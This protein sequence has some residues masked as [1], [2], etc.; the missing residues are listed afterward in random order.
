MSG[1]LIDGKPI[2]MKVRAEAAERAAAFAQAYGR[3]PGLHVVLVGED[4]ASQVYVRN[5][6]RAC[7]KAGLAGQ[8]HRVS[9]DLGQGRLLALVDE[10]NTD[11][12]VDGILVQMPLP[13]GYDE[14]EV[15]ARIDPA[16]DVDGLTAVSAGRLALGVPGLCPC[17][18]VGCMRMLAEIGCDPEGKRAVVLGRSNLVGK[19]IAQL[20]LQRNATV[21]IA[22]SRTKQ[23]GDLVREGDIVVAAVGRRAL[24]QGDWIKPGAVVLDVGINRGEDGQIYGDVD[25]EPARERASFIT[26][27]PGGVGR[28]TVAVLLSNTVDAAYARAA[29]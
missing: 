1:Q 13:H 25:F 28:M 18:P 6:E 23:L 7:R 9:A 19:P 20:L 14:L 2:A 22:H 27:V 21:T 8:V 17:T 10:L 15:I 12:K 11:P 5:K 16:K 29:G 4:H 26:P 3:P 24:V